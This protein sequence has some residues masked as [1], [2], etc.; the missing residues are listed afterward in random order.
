MRNGANGVH[1]PREELVDV[2]TGKD[3]LR[4]ED[5]TAAKVNAPAVSDAPPAP[6]A[7]KE[8]LKKDP[9]ADAKR[10]VA[11]DVAEQAQAAPAELP[12]EPA[13]ASKEPDPEPEETAGVAETEA[14]LSEEYIGS[15]PKLRDILSHMHSAGLRDFEA[16]VS[17]CEERRSKVAILS[18]IPN[19]KERVNKT[20]FV[21]GYSDAEITGLPPQ[22]SDA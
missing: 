20:L 16:L 6:K 11:D 15:A 7:K 12:K 14:G 2:A 21:M 1:A 8:K 19:M 18:K 13:R 17:A 5:M 22:A 3:R 10:T 9:A 4:G